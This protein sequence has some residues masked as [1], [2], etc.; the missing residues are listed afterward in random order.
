[1]D[2]AGLCSPGEWEVAH[3]RFPDDHKAFIDGLLKCERK[4]QEVDKSMNFK[5][6]LLTISMR[7]LAESRFSVEAVEEIR[8]SF[9]MILKE[10]THGDGLPEA[11]TLSRCARS[12]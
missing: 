10:S 2:G 11:G 3:C 5:T 7:R 8:D 6:I 4:L 1:M 9:H 12:G